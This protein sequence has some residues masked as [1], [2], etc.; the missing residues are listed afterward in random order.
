MN[1]MHLSLIFVKIGYAPE[2]QGFH[3][4]IVNQPYVNNFIWHKVK[5]P[6]GSIED[7]TF[8]CSNV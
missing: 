7:T 3:V 5:L 4:I 1:L 2:K 6:N 8:Y